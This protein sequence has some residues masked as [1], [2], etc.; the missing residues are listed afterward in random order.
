MKRNEK[1][2]KNKGGK[3]EKVF[4]FQERK[5]RKERKEN[6]FQFMNL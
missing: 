1:E 6:K 2:L 5:K 3:A 4:H